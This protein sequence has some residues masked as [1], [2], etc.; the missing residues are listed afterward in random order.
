M[1]N[2]MKSKSSTILFFSAIPFLAIIIFSTFN[3]TE[4]N[5]SEL[6]YYGSGQ[7]VNNFSEV[8]EKN[9]IPVPNFSFTNQD[10][11][12]INQSLIKNKIWV[13][14][15]FFTHCGTI[16]PKMSSNLQQVQLEFESNDDVKII[17]FTCDPLHDNAEQLLNYAH[18]YNAN[19]KQW[20]FATGEKQSLYRFARKGL[21]VVATDGDGG[22][23][24]FIHSQNM[25]LIDKAGYIRGYYDGTDHQQVKQLINDIKKI[26]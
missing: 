15:F 13:A 23:N 26:L 17:S 10:G 14:D 18:S 7:I 24:D 22:P 2:K 8:K 19:T 20:Q 3:Y 6:P 9:I 21:Q 25:V 1:N 11:K 12:N 5:K 4:K 16:C